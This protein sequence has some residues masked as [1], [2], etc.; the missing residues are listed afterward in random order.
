MVVGWYRKLSISID[1]IIALDQRN[2][3]SQ[4]RKMGKE[5]KKGISSFEI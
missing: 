3:Q 2:L 5:N 1:K 4:D